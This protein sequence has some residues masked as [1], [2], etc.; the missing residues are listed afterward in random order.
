MIDENHPYFFISKQKRFLDSK[1]NFSKYIY[2]PDSLIDER[3]HFSIKGNRLSLDAI[4][5]AIRSLEPYEELA[6]HSTVVINKRTYHIPMI[7]FA[8]KEELDS[9]SIQRLQIFIGKP[10]LQNMSFFRSGRS[11]HAYA[12][13]LLE[14]KEWIK[15]MGGLLLVNKANEPDIIDT[16]WVGHRLVGG[17]SSLRWS[18]NTPHYKSMPSKI[19]FPT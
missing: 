14:P 17:Y 12:H 19:H 16:R 6:M 5:E 13:K 4:N 11:F 3:K 8:L 9:K 1:L 18:C 7:D 15:F 10:I 2:R